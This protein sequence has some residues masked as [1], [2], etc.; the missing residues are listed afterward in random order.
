MSTSVEKTGPEMVIA[1]GKTDTAAAWP[2]GFH[3]DATG[4]WSQ[5]DESK[6]PNKLTGSFKIVGKTRD[7]KGHGWGLYA[8]W[9]DLDGQRHSSVIS[10]ADLM[11]E[12]AGV[13]RPLTSAGLWISTKA[14]DIGQLKEALTGV[15]CET[16]VRL[17]NRAGFYSNAFVLPTHTIG[18]NTRE[19]VVFDGKADAARYATAGSLQDWKDKV[20][21]LCAGN[22]RAVFACSVGFAGPVNDLLQGEG[23]GFH[24][25]GSSSL[26][27]TTLL[28][29]AGSIYGGGDR[30]GFA[31][32]WHGTENGLE[33]I[34]RA[35]SGAVLVLDEMGQV[36]S[37]SIGNIVY[38]LINGMG[39]A[40]A[41]RNAELKSQASWRIML[42]SS[43]ELGLADKIAEG[44]KKPRAGQLAR[45]VD[46]PADAGQGSGAFEDTKG[47]E[48][49]VF[50]EAL[51]NAALSIYGTAGPAFIEGLLADKEAIEKAAR[52]RIQAMTTKLLDGIPASDGQAH[53]V[54]ARFALVG[55]AGGLGQEILD[56]PWAA[57]EAEHA[58]AV[59][60]K[61]WRE[62]RGGEGPGEL[63]AAMNALRAAIQAHG[64]SRF[65]NLDPIPSDLSTPVQPGAIR[66]LLGYR[67]THKDE[68]VWGFTATGWKEV[69]G[70]VGQPS[71]VAKLMAESGI[72]VAGSDQAHRLAKRIGGRTQNLIAVKASALEEGGL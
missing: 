3:Q 58:A 47:M 7:Q 36:D 21:R 20:A 51:K 39:K 42:L 9:E 66:D 27:K 23:G 64:E 18:D 19:Q 4:L 62:A 16:R 70:G 72:L 65:R 1:P 12:G 68:L 45:L 46:I 49:A 13:F 33:S 40:R 37:R 35:H 57:G 30:M 53:R 71:T 8:T 24:L 54:A 6:P 50:S 15:M 60:F 22:T 44:G 25:V 56:L 52:T 38:M 34:A 26:G 55:V 2:P 5:K 48:P 29:L 28:T 14:A 63:V 10:F 69:V 17:T 59:C 67:F 32:T 11:G 61:A 43:G 41:T 31:H